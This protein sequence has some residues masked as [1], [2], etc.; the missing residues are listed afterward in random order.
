MNVFGQCGGNTTF[1]PPAEPEPDWEPLEQHDRRYQI[2]AAYFYNGH[3]L[4]AASRFREIAQTPES[5]WRDLARYLVPR[6]LAREALVNEND[7]E[8]HL[9]AALDGYR[10]LANDEDYPIDDLPVAGQIRH[11]EAQRDPTA[12]RRVIEELIV[13]RPDQATAQD[14]RDYVYLRRRWN[15]WSYDDE[16]SEFERWRRLLSERD[17]TAALEHW[18]D[19]RSLPW[20]FMALEK[21]DFRLGV[22]ALTELLD[23]ADALPDETPGHFNILLNR[24]RIRGLLGESE[25]VSRLFEDA[26]ED[27]IEKSDMNLVR[28][29]AAE[30]ALNW[31]SY[32][33]WVSVKP[34]SLPWTDDFARRLPANFNRITTDTP[35]FFWETAALLNRAFTP[36][37]FL[38]VIDSPG[39]GAYQRGRMAIAGWTKAMLMDDLTN[40]V[41]LSRHVRRNV[42]FL[43]D[44]FG[45]F[46][47]AHDM[48]FEAARIILEYPAFSPWMWG[49]AGRVQHH[50]VRRDDGTYRERRPIPDHVA[51]GLNWLNWWCASSEET[52]ERI[53]IPDAV[54]QHP[55]FSHYSEAEIDASRRMVDLRRTAATTAFGPHVIRYAKNNLDDPRVPRTLHRLVFATRHACMT[56]PGEIS[57]A[58]FALLHKHFPDSEWAEKTPYWYD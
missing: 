56:V 37:M 39:L 32:F 17:S 19:R 27:G 9:Q 22:S 18:R 23:A 24:I 44:D 15:A 29:A 57:R 40:A 47:D 52:I 54:L 1:D 49:D 6:S 46:E 14:M 26:V 7:E 20:L 48:H 16:A 43:A 3:Y 34:L 28:M 25:V 31:N 36:A 58:A 41:E 11:L 21:A 55:R 50:L 10:E 30:G 5:P 42:P 53:R 2:A 35:V 51:D 13:N 12:T 38:E 33:R 8:R 45:V 4:E